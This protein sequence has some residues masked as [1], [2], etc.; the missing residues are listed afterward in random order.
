MHHFLLRRG[1]IRLVY[2]S[3]S[4]SFRYLKSYILKENIT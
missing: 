4:I 1:Q 3:V 2:I